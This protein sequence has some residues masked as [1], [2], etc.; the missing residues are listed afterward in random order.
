MLSQ[1]FEPLLGASPIDGRP[2]PALADSWT[3]SADGLTYTFKLNPDAKWHDGVDVTADDVAFS[4]DAVLNPNLNSQYRSQVREVVKSYR[5]IDPDTF[6]ITATDRF[7]TFL[8]NAPASV[9]IMPKHAA[10]P[11]AR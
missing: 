7:V 3:V 1:V 6:E 4:F 2:I 11:S 10:T 8:Y 9:F 5:V